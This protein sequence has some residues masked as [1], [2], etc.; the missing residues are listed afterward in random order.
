LALLTRLIAGRQLWRQQP[1]VGGLDGELA[2]ILIIMM[3]DE[4]RPRTSNDTR[5][6]LTVALVKPARGASWS[7]SAML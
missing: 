5:H 7:S 1:V 6:A 2:D 3:E 4:P